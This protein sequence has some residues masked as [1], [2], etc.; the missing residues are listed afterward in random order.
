[1]GL[2]KIGIITQARM[3]STRLHGK[4]MK[5]VGGRELL[6]YHIKRLQK[7]GLTVFVA[8]SVLPTDQV[9]ADFCEG[10]GV[11]CFRGSESN[12]LKRFYDCA[13][14]N[15]IDVIVRVTSDC[16][17]IDGELIKRGVETFLSGKNDWLYVSNCLDR[18]YPRGFDFEVFSFSALKEAF[19]NATLDIDL[20]HVTP[21]LNQNRNGKMTFWEIKSTQNHSDYRITVDTPEDFEVIRRLIEEEGCAEKSES[22]ITDI[23]F[24]KA[25]IRQINAQIE[26]K[27]V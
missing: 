23:L 16:P 7:S 26:Q 17:L 12:V 14:F 5:K 25:E 3:G 6:H 11:S 8:T 20:E 27:K 15:H 13:E 22:E 19:E 24:R 9:I 18:T 21:Y 2:E 10:I 4:V 1:M